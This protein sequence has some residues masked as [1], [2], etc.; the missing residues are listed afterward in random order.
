MGVFGAVGAT[1][2]GSHLL[3]AAYGTHLDG[4]GRGCGKADGGML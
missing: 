1:E 2:I 4:G 3:S